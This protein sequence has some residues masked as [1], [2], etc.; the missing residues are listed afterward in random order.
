MNLR[1]QLL[2]ILQASEKPL[3]VDQLTER[4]QLASTDDFKELIR[5]LNALEEEGAIGRTRTNRYGTL[6]TLGQVAGIISIH[7]RG[8]G[9][10]SVEGE[11][12]DVFLPPDQLKDVYHGDTILVKKREDN[13]GKTEGILLKVLKRGL[14]EFVGT[15]T[16][17]SGRLDQFAFI[18]PDDK[19]INFWPVVNPDKSLGAVD[20]HKVVVRITKY[21]DGRFAGACDVVRI[22]GH[23]NDPGV[24]ILSIVY[25]H[26]IPTEFPE[27]VIAQ[28][29][30]VPDEADEKDFIGRVDLRDET[31][32]TI[33]GEDAKDLDD[34]FHVKKLDNGNYELGV[35]IADV[36]HY[37]KEGS[38]LDVE[39]FERG[40]S[41]Y[42]V[43][44]V[45]PMLP[46]RL[47]NGICSLNPHVNRLTLSCVME[48]SP[49]NGKVV[50]HDLFPSVIK[51]TERMTY[52][53]VREI[54]ERDDEETLKKYE[55]FIGE[56]DLMAEL[57]EVLRKRRNSRGAINFDFAEAKVVVNEEGKPADIVLRPRSVAEKLIEEF[58]LAANETV[59][60]HFHKMDVPFIYRVH[61]NPK[62]DKLDFFFDFVANFGVHIERIKGQTVEPKTLQKIL[63][64][65]DGEPEEPVIS[66]I[67]LRSMQQAKYDDVSLGH[68]GLATDFYTHF[69]SP[70]R[71]YPDL[72]VHRLMRTYVFN[73]DL[74]EKTIAKYEDRLG[75]IAEQAS[76]R[77]RRSVDAERE[78]QALKKAE[79][80]EAHLGEEFDGVVAGVTNFGMFIE[81]PNT[82]EGLVR[83]QSMDDYYH[84]DESQLMLLGER[85]KRQF[86]IGDAV[87][88]KVD[89]VNLDERT[90]DFTVV[91]MPKREQSSRRQ[92]TTIKAK[93]GRPKKDEKDR[94][95][96]RGRDDKKKRGKPGRPGKP[97]K[98]GEK[99]KRDGEKSSQGR[100]ALDLKK[101]DKHKRKGDAKRGAKKRR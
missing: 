83:L 80:M 86:R 2:E 54:I 44:R 46:H 91:G 11:A 81:L 64:A 100:S 12:E 63:K 16:L 59:A 20:G 62:P 79:Y 68:F 53:N 55:P 60:E 42:L 94:R 39:A 48:I 29:N 51:T 7:Q 26:G 43:D 4:L 95:G 6:A 41:V 72:I 24:D 21:P 71:R 82:I 58:M 40:T 78:T 69:T 3:S 35:H 75:A 30:A 92:P 56:F 25:K 77:E 5:T 90:I 22:I 14:S 9:F 52:T 50:R 76:K 13:R 10:L 96:G 87:R 32:F 18:E 70:I 85:T 17:P 101:K 49:Q 15:Y 66:T 99:P 33:D 31:I 98:P 57:A 61:D 19:R 1:D 67:M 74:S 38:P 73:N 37:V 34:A 93:G 45:I 84:F 89:A 97:G 28:A 36:S 65:I 8:F 88:V 23:K 47:S 27:D